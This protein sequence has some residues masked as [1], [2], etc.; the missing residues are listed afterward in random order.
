M[1][2]NTQKYIDHGNVN[3][4]W[5]GDDKFW[6]RTLTPEGSEFILVN[7]AK[8]TK[9]VAFDQQKLATVLSTETGRSYTAVHATVSIF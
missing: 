2:Y 4:N 1:G 9:T 8:G 3:A 5:I 7:A 6:Y